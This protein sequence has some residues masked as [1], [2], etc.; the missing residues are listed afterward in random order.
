MA[1]SSSVAQAP[2]GAPVSE[3]LT[4]EN[5]LLWKAQIMP[6][7]RGAQLDSILDGSCAAPAKTLEI[8]TDDKKT[9]T[10]VNP[11]YERWI[12]KDQQLLSYILNSL[13]TGVLSQVAT[14][15]SSASVWAALDKKGDMQG[16]PI[17][18]CN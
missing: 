7:I 18:T 16:S 5:F 10:I 13:T 4:R 12:A 8:T 9:A 15:T 14:L 2:L 11:E 1:S 3:K 6:A 17:C